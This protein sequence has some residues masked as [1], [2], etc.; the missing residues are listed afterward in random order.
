MHL[1][2]QKDKQ[3]NCTPEFLILSALKLP[4]CRLISFYNNHLYTYRIQEFQNIFEKN[5]CNCFEQLFYIFLE[6]VYMEL[7]MLAVLTESNTCIRYCE[8]LQQSQWIVPI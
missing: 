3:D 6:N 8:T 4:S 5:L 2:F 1:K 7:N